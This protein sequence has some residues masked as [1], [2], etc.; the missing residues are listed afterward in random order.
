[1][2]AFGEVGV[3]KTALL[4]HAAKTYR[5]DLAYLFCDRGTVAGGLPG[6]LPLPE[7]LEKQLSGL[8]PEF[9]VPTFEE[10]CRSHSW[11]RALKKG[12]EAAASIAT[13]AVLPSPASRFAWETYERVKASLSLDRAILPLGTE[14]DDLRLLYILERLRAAPSVVH[15]DHSGLLEQGELKFILHLLDTTPAIFF[16]EYQSLDPTLALSLEA[17]LSS[18]KRLELSVERLPLEYA[19]RL[20]ASLPNRFS[21][22]LREQF[23]RDGNLRPFDEV[24]YLNAHSADVAENFDASEDAL[25][26]LTEERVLTL[27]R[28]DLNVMLAIAA[29]AGPVDRGLLA[30]FLFS[31]E[32]AGQTKLPLDIDK[33]LDHLDE[34]LLAIATSSDVSCQSRV[35]DVIRRRVDIA[36]IN[37][38]FQKLWR[39]FYRSASTLGVFVS[40]ADRCRQIL[41]QCASLND[42]TGIASALRE[43]GQK[44]I[45]SRNPKSIVSYLK[46]ITSRLESNG[47]TF[48]HILPRVAL[49]QC[50]FFYEAGWFDEA[51]AC[52]DLVAKKP[53]SFK[54]LQA[55]LYCA[56]E[57]QARGISLAEKHL[58]ELSDK[59]RDLDAELCLQ[60]IR[61]HGLRNSNQLASARSLYKATISQR[62]F[63]GRNAYVTLLRFADLCLFTD[64]D[65]PDCLR[66]LERAIEEADRFGFHG[67]L[68]SACISLS[69]L[70]GYTSDLDRAEL[71]LDKASEIARDVW[72]QQST[73][74][75][76]RAVIS[77]YREDTSTEAIRLLEQAL[78]L[79][80]ETLDKLLI[81]LNMLIW[82]AS[83][84]DVDRS[85]QIEER[86]RS[87]ISLS[88]LDTEIK[89][90]ALFNLE[91]MS[92]RFGRV[93]EADIY[94]K[95]W[96]PL[97]SGVDE[98]Y[99]SFRRTGKTDHTESR[100]KLDFHPVYLAHW[101]LGLI[102]FQAISDDASDHV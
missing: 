30:E 81:Q 62:H 45:N 68:A 64:E 69:Q 95:S 100:R 15:I 1:M 17:N 83:V 7:L 3:G 32:A 31:S 34:R 76:N 93:D 57:F 19:D 55:E 94:R 16:I 48:A 65:L 84:G 29:H 86:L 98:A 92:R 97:R 8:A 79:S 9:N 42:L 26:R 101:H 59:P 91:A 54:Y 10:F 90:I 66:H 52:L 51:L 18:A 73:L 33:T 6:G 56:S 21:A 78:V 70:L 75:A 14:P 67:E 38:S 35:H 11:T 89:R 60:L 63:S 82:H 87:F 71:L 23:A 43:L 39:D 53:R 25:S 22:S 28:S 50:R 102:P 37:I 5:S 2:V 13:K 12:S 36:A 88:G 61:M 44:G 77:L 85:L 20:F 24:A 41:Y 80:Y 72:L 46:Q 58:R 99:W 49:E 47:S 96:A 74:L 27:S 40:D 4:R